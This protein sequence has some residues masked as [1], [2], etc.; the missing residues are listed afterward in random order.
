VSNVARPGTDE[1]RE[2]ADTV[3]GYRFELPPI[4]STS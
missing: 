2:A 1:D 4:S 3:A